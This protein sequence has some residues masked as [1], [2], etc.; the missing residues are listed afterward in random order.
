MAGIGRPGLG[1]RRGGIEQLVEGVFG[2][3]LGAPG[4]FRGAGGGEATG[5]GRDTRHGGPRWQEM[6]ELSPQI[7]LQSAGHRVELN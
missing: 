6:G 5:F 4:V 1:S 2:R 3:V 7:A